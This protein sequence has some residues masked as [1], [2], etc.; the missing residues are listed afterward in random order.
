MSPF[1]R[2]LGLGVLLY[3]LGGRIPFVGG[4]LGWIALGLGGFLLA[5]FAADRLSGMQSPVGY[6]FGMGA[7]VGAVVA[8]I[9]VLLN[10]G[11][12]LVVISHVGAA[13]AAGAGLSAIGGIIHLFFAPLVGGFFGGLGGLIGAAGIRKE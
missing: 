4:I 8:V 11:L 5:R 9:G 1:W 12:D 13:G 7:L 3:F 10:I 6:G 2:A